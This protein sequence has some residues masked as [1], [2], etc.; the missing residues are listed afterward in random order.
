[1]KFDMAGRLALQQFRLVLMHSSERFRSE[2]DKT[3][4]FIRELAFHKIEI[5]SNLYQA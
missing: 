3:I 5:I 4:A 1:M 2:L